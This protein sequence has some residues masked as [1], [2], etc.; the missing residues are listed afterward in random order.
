MGSYPNYLE[1]YSYIINYALLKCAYTENVKTQIEI[2]NEL[3]MVEGLIYEN[4][5]PTATCER[6][7]FTN[8][9]AKKVDAIRQ[10]LS[11]VLKSGEITD[12]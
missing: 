10:H 5:S 12:K 4:F 1:Y 8:D 3:N 6:I 9:N 7:F 11:C 2:C